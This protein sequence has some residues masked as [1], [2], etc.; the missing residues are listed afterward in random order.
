MFIKIQMMYSSS[1]CRMY[2]ILND[3]SLIKYIIKM[4][5]KILN[6]HLINTVNLLAYLH[7]IKNKYK[8]V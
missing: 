4:H 5:F 7:H 3:W 1:I 8:T 2:M 6:K